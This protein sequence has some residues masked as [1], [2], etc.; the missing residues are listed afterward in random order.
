MQ[1]N[2]CQHTSTGEDKH[3]L[4]NTRA[5]CMQRETCTGRHAQRDTLKALGPDQRRQHQA[6]VARHVVQQ[7]GLFAPQAT[8]KMRQEAWNS[9][10]LPTSVL[11]GPSLS[12]Q[13]SLKVPKIARSRPRS[14]GGRLHGY[15]E[16]L[17][18]LA[19]ATRAATPRPFLFLPMSGII[20]WLPSC[21]C[22]ILIVIA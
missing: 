16:T 13:C 17:F 12:V 11:L 15:S 22:L 8:L 4:Q 3:T 7:R 1:P 20:I 9:P 5:H 18:E 6:T 14:G 21:M 10:S 19:S 2:K